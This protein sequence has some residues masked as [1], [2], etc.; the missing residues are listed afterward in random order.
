MPS[1][2][3]HPEGLHLLRL[4]KNKKISIMIIKATTIPVYLVMFY[5]SIHMIAHVPQRNEGRIH[6]ITVCRRNLVLPGHD[7]RNSPPA[8]KNTWTSEHTTTNQ[9]SLQLSYNK[10]TFPSCSY[11]D[12]IWDEPEQ[13]T[14]TD[15]E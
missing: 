7:G 1:D 11:G 13:T 4:K 10:L 8:E 6:F 12:K 3:F 14:R 2:N 15:I 9:N 5:L